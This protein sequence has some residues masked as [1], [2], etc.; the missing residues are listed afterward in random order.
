M[1][2]ARVSFDPTYGL[3]LRI[4]DIDPAFT[5]GDLEKEKQE[6]L[7]KL[8]AQGLFTQ[9]KSLKI[10]LLL[11]RIAIISVE[12]SKGYADFLNVL[13]TNSWNYKFFHL[14]FPSLLQG[15]KAV[16]SITGQLKR[17]RKVIDHFDAVAIIRGGG[18]DIGLSCFNNFDLAREVALFPIPVITGIGHTTNETVV[19]MISY[20]NAITP[21]K[22]AEYL[23]QIFHN[24]SV[25]VHHA[26]EKIIAQSVRII[27]DE[28]LVL[29]S[30]VKLFRSVTE[31]VLTGH[32]NWL[33]QQI[34]NVQQQIFYRL[35]SEKE[36]LVNVSEAIKRGVNVLCIKMKEN[37]L[38]SVSILE[39][40][41]VVQLKQLNMI[42]D[43]N[44]KSI[45][46][47]SPQNVLKRGFSITL[48]NGSAVKLVNQVKE[49]DLIE[50]IVF[51][52]KINS[53]VKS[54]KKQ[55]KN[56]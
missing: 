12:T 22:I 5:L 3:A 40:V 34:I 17:I 48:I 11:Q 33:T 1:F 38:H 7:R 28:K 41:I 37:I 39:K 2:L 23:L 50:T 27:S 56:E 10:P 49:N 52:G 44:E 15:E 32:R 42:L 16:A 55:R 13:N 19:E 6:T 25:P 53:I 36:Y 9:N 20:Q 54:K 4:I 14:L 47:M 51:D 18:G 21:T 24:F 8:K 45:N 26:E 43:A 35:R 46:N 29:L 30:E 31:T